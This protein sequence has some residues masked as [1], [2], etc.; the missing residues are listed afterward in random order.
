MIWWN[1]VNFL[2]RTTRQTAQVGVLA[3]SLSRRQ[4]GL[5]VLPMLV[6]LAVMALSPALSEV[7]PSSPN[8]TLPQR[9]AI[10]QA[11]K[12][13]YI[14]QTGKVVI[15]PQSY[16]RYGGANAPYSISDAEDFA[17]N[18]GLAI[19]KIG[20][21]WGYLNPTGKLAITAQFDDAKPFR[22]GRAAVRM[23]EKWGFI[24]NTGTMVIKPQFNVVQDFSDGLSQVWDGKKYRYI[25]RNG[26][27]VIDTKFTILNDGNFVEGLALV[28]IRE[29]QQWGFIDKSGKLV[30]APG[31]KGLSNFSEGL[32]RVAINQKYGFINQTGK[33]VICPQFDQVNDG[34]AEGLAAVKIGD[35]WGFI[36]NTG[37]VVIQP[38]FEEAKPFSEGLARV[39]FKHNG[40]CSNQIW[41]YI[42]QTGKM[43][44]KPQFEEVLSFRNG[45]AAVMVQIGNWSYIDKTG[46]L[47]WSAQ[48]D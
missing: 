25:D 48:E 7:H 19:A 39:A 42:D 43:V 45:L 37:K 23:G 6:G 10:R 40:C 46:R 24:D 33:V 4:L 28:L 3:K 35:K 47:I 27:I 16:N 44:I 29:Q 12:I 22:E 36:N 32:A 31:L 34:F 18:E 11:K 17:F 13:G 8:S 14:D 2:K 20:Q 9:F 5:F 38:Q 21:K 30:I 1:P 41:G 15:P 26:K